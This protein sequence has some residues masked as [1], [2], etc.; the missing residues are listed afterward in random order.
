MRFL[1]L[2]IDFSIGL[3]GV[4]LAYLV[5]FDAMIPE[6][7]ARQMFLMA[8]LIATLRLVAN[9]LNGVY[10]VVWRYVGIREAIVF[11]RAVLTLS[12]LLLV[13]RLLAPTDAIAIK[14]PISI[15][16]LEAMFCYLGL[17]SSRLLRRIVHESSRRDPTVDSAEGTATLLI[18]AGQHG[19]AIAKEAL[20]HREALG[21]RPIGFLDDDLNKAGMEVSGI[22]VLGTLDDVREVIKHTDVKQAIITS[23]AVSSKAIVKLI[24]VCRPMGVH[25]R[26]VPGLLEL[27]DQGLSAKSLRDVRIEDL[28]SRDP[29]P[30]SMSME[31]LRGVLAGKRIM[32]TGAGG[33]IGSELCRQLMALGPA[34]LFL[35]ER[36][37]NN[38]F[39]VHKDTCSDSHGVCVPVLADIRDRKAIDRIFGELKPQIVFHAAAF[40]HVPMMERFPTE[41]AGNNVFGTRNL[42][43]LAD[44]HGVENFVMISTDKAVNPSSVMGATKRLAEI[45][46]QR[47]A[48]SSKTRFSC[49][50]FGNVLGSRGSVIP[51]FREQI[52]RGGP[53][54]VT[55]SEATRYFMT[56]PEAAN[57]VIQAGM[58]GDSGEVFVLDMGEPVKIMDL[59]KQ[60]IHLSGL[61]EDQVP[62]KIMGSRPGEKLFEELK[63]N[64][65]GISETKLR[66]VYRVEPE[67]FSELSISEIL[68]RIDFAIRANDHGGVRAALEDL[69][70]GF[71]KKPQTMTGTGPTAHL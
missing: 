36:D 20:R 58:L 26:T 16:V 50:R 15:I 70:I 27:L 41:S 9:Q 33:S 43:E 21:I 1:Q 7:F 5:R 52:R 25:V 17:T 53:V 38:L 57:L 56:I 42:A 34:K 29:I 63:T 54:T 13:L 39:E 10:R 35:L 2:G 67:A 61:T 11:A 51:I 68:E 23:S 64:S 45:L 22:K 60:M 30:P 24:D 6:A 66:K 12:V 8:P 3:I 14:V 37:E 18:G 71:T 59:A 32:V 46:I 69:E 65:E 49:V 62:I 4:I 40:K 47:M 19:L 48:P 44:Q 28:L 55:H 31:D